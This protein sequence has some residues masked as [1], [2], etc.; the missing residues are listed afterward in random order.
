MSCGVAYYFLQ[1]FPDQATLFLVCLSMSGVILRREALHLLACDGAPTTIITF[2]QTD[3]F[4][5]QNRHK[6]ISQ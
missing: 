4:S 1:I 2:Q 5:L 6:M 3:I